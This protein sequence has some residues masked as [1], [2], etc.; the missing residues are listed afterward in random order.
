L[1]SISNM[2]SD[3]GKQDI[4][5]YYLVLESLI[6]ESGLLHDNEAVSATALSTI[7]TLVSKLKARMIPAIPCL[8]LNIFNV[9]KKAIN[10]LESEE[11][12]DSAEI[13]IQSLILSLITIIESV[14]LFITSYIPQ[15]ILLI[16]NERLHKIVILDQCLNQLSCKLGTSVEHTSLFPLIVNSTHN[17]MSAGGSNL[18]KLLQ[19]LDIS[20]G[21]TSSAAILELR[22]QWQ[23]FFLDLFDYRKFLKSLEMVY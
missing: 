9:S 1:L 10:N 13:L 5:R 17:S 7:S 8:M 2:A 6:G 18:T 3:M 12:K 15:I 4:E 16:T 14:P 21:V 22:S 20:I 23:K 11:K 19:L